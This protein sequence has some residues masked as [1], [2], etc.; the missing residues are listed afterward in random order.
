MRVTAQ[1]KDATRLR[2][3]ESALDL[4]K[5]GGFEATTTRDIARRAGI[6]TGTLFNYF[7]TKD[8]ILAHLAGD[9]LAKA[10]ATFARQAIE[11]DLEE[12]LFALI[13]AEL[14]QLRPYRKFLTAL[15]E[16]QLSPL[17][18]SKHAGSDESLR[19]AHLETMGGIARKHGVVELS[20]LAL[21][22]YW[23]LYTGVLAF[24]SA[25]TSPKQEDTLALLDQSLHMFTAWLRGTPGDLNER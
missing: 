13:A 14:R 11:A 5:N 23:T 20:P 21:Q 9:A 25:D 12:E 1:E 16:T 18:A 4:F 19:V 17:V 8:T 6:A 15:L 24:W 10:R 2:I 22:I 3:V 7:E